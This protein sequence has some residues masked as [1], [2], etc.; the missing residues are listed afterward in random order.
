METCRRAQIQQS[1][2]SLADSYKVMMELMERTFDLLCEVQE[3]DP[4]TYLRTRSVPASIQIG[5]HAFAIDPAVLSIKYR[6]KICFLGDTL[7]FKLITYLARR[8][9]A[10]FTYESLLTEVWDGAVRS[11]DAVRSVVKILRSKL[12]QAGLADLADAIDGTV[13]RHYALKLAR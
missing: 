11:D 8:P 9:N 13:R 10:Y 6:G 3:L 4:L 1:L 12:R 7:C 5:K 2:R